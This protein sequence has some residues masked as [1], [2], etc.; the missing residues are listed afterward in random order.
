LERKL[1][2]VLPPSYYAR[3]TIVT[4]HLLLGDGGT[5]AKPNASRAANL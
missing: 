2:F 5:T 3:H 1:L 4:A